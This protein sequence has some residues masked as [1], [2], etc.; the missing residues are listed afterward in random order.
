MLCLKEI[1][2]SLFLQAKKLINERLIGSTIDKSV[3]AGQYRNSRIRFDR[4][5]SL[6]F[7]K[8]GTQNFTGS[9]RVRFSVITFQFDMYLRPDLHS[10][11]LVTY[12]P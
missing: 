1:Y 4:A 2:Y 9:H 11:E 7:R 8:K 3:C 5:D 10:T 6:A 12:S